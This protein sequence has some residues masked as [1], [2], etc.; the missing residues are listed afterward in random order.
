[1]GT[2]TGNITSLSYKSTRTCS[3]NCLIKH[4][5]RVVF[6]FGQDP[7]KVF[8]RPEREFLLMCLE[9][10]VLKGLLIGM[11]GHYRQALSEEH[12]VKL[13]QSLAKSFEHDRT[14]G[15]VLHG[16]GLSDVKCVAALL[17]N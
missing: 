5:F 16:Q 3:R 7:E 12:V 14:L 15:G 8:E 11:A 1:M 10:A 6:P 2:R 9:F 13:V 4:I 17:K